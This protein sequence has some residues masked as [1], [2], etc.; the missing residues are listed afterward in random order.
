LEASQA[1][2]TAIVS[3][4]PARLFEGTIYD[5]TVDPGEPGGGDETTI[6]ATGERPFLVVRAGARAS[7]LESR[8]DPDAVALVEPL[9]TVDSRWV[10]ARNLAEGDTL[11]TMSADGVAGTATVAKVR[12]RHAV[13]PVYNLTVRGTSRYL[14][15]ACGVVVHNKGEGAGSGGSRFVGPV[16]VVDRRT[17]KVFEGTVDLKPTLD[18]IQ[19]GVRDPHVR[20][21][22]IFRNDQ[23]LLPAKPNGY[24]REF[25]HRT[26][27][28]DHVGP[29]RVVIGRGGEVYYTPDHYD[30]FIPV[31]LPGR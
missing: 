15:G 31:S 27:G 2:T 18:R 7:A 19:R 25:V 26:P 10:P 9:D 30:S 16:R 23:G 1:P 8:A 17:G 4:T 21:G 5:I 14:V 11:R 24:Y 22:S 12:A 29:Q 6:S 28:I 3:A 13:A 20:D